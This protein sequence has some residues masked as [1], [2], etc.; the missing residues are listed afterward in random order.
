MKRSELISRDKKD[1]TLKNEKLIKADLKFL[2]RT[3]ES[4][5]RNIEDLEESIEERLSTLTPI[6]S[7]TVEAQYGSLKDFKE[8]LDLYKSFKKAY[9]GA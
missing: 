4:I 3:I 2:N 5:E 7:S 1:E 9:Y 8:K 6:D